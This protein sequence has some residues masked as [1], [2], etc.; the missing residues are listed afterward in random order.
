M[1]AFKNTLKAERIKI[2]SL[3]FPWWILGVWTVLA[4]VSS[5]FTGQ[6]IRE[7]P[8]EASLDSYTVAVHSPGLFL[9]LLFA[10]LVVTL[11]YRFDLNVPTTLA[12]PSSMQVALAK[13]V[14]TAPVLMMASL[15][16]LIVSPIPGY[17]MAN[18]G[19]GPDFTSVYLNSLWRVPLAVT[20]VVAMSQGLAMLLK[21]TAAVVGLGLI[22]ALIVPGLEYFGKVGNWI[23][24]YSPYNGL[25][26]LITGDGLLSTKETALVMV[27]L[28]AW[29]LALWF[30]GVWLD[31]KRDS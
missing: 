1:N 29:T 8:N 14:V 20:I 16:L 28:L 26:T 4:L 27:A 25:D 17:F 13:Y 30:G 5:F 23:F 18:P 19:G 3:S 10:T 9:V 24:T 6:V 15:V 11:D 2:F 22:T 31:R 7:S 21:R 12:T